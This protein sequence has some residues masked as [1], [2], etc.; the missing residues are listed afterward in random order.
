MRRED[1]AALSR[2]VAAVRL[3][4]LG[5]AVAVILAAVWLFIDWRGTAAWGLLAACCRTVEPPPDPHLD[6]V[7]R[8]GE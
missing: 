4:R 7:T 5:Q 1:Q 8:R 2:H 3:A 6:R